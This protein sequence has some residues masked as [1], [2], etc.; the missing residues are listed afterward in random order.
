MSGAAR[1]PAGAVLVTGATSQIG[2]FVLRRLRAA[3]SEV[4]ALGRRRPD[5]EPG[6]RMRFVESDL[7]D[8]TPAIGASLSSVVHIAGIW[9]LPPHVQALYDLGVRRIVCFSSTSISVKETSANSGERALVA[10]MVEAEE[11]VAAQCENLGIGWTIL[12]PTL[13]YG[14]GIDRNVSRAA[15]FIRRFGF[16]PLAVDANGLRQPVHADDLAAAAL[17]ALAAP[18][19]VGRIF[20]LGGGETL[21]YREMIGRIFDVLER[22]R[23]FAPMP[24]LEFLANTAGILLRR[25]EVTG[26]MVRRMRQD[27]VCDNRPAAA[28]L[29]HRPR[30]FLAGGRLDLGHAPKSV[31]TRSQS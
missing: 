10:R 16:Y 20:E 26:D 1:D 4:V 15:R 7:N 9:L 5:I 17:S 18:A 24:F 3:N 19:A 14:L 25:P 13:V 6:P 21:P 30:G 8:A 28:D 27:L 11:R 23:R 29:A 12:R 31:D 2:H 22:P